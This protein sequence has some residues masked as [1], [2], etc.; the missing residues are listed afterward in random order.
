MFEWK[1]NYSKQEKVISSIFC[2]APKFYLHVSPLKWPK[3]RRWRFG[4]LTISCLG[5][6]RF[7]GP[8]K[9]LLKSG[10]RW[11]FIFSNSFYG[12]KIKRYSLTIK[13]RNIKNISILLVKNFISFKLVVWAQEPVKLKFITPK[14]LVW[15]KKKLL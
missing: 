13:I 4:N 9:K 1:K 6:H 5:V 3:Y 10:L 2:F 11:K 7:G 8:T 15:M 12:I 14:R